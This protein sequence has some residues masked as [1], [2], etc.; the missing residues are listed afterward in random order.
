ML[1]RMRDQAR[2]KRSS[3]GSRVSCSFPDIHLLLLLTFL[4][5]SSLHLSLPPSRFD[6]YDRAYT[7]LDYD[8]H[9]ARRAE[10]PAV[11]SE[12]F[13]EV[14]RLSPCSIAVLVSC[15]CLRMTELTRALMRLPLIVTLKQAHVEMRE[16]N[17]GGR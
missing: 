13:E 15:I 7:R 14:L 17:G 12:A 1:S 16:V 11:P 5:L 3:E 10:R 6:C 4:P 2:R 8:P 9:T